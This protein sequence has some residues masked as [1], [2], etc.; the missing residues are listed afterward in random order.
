M[1]WYGRSD[2]VEDK[3]KSDTCGPDLGRYSVWVDIVDQYVVV[4]TKGD[5][6]NRDVDAL[7]AAIQ[8]CLTVIPLAQFQVAPMVKYEVL[9]LLTKRDMATAR[10]ATVYKRL[11]DTHGEDAIFEGGFIDMGSL[12]QNYH[13]KFQVFG[14]GSRWFCLYNSS[15]LVWARF[16]CVRFS[17]LTG[18]CYQWTD[19]RHARGS[20]GHYGEYAR[21]G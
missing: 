9:R 15:R 5:K 13:G 1:L 17:C 12:T 7:T 2:E 11:G 14:F 4:W 16:A 19:S 3:Y 18:V 6:S 8:E 20:Q 10:S 21:N